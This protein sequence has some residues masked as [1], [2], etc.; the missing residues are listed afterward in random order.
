[1]AKTP[2]IECQP[3]LIEYPAD[4][5]VKAMGLNDGNFE[6]LVRGIVLPLIVPAEPKKITTV[7]SSGGKYLSVSVHFTAISQLQLENIY[8]ALREEARV[9]FTL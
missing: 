3:S 9:L 6:H 7:G 8:R 5:S 4:L 2:A 1:M